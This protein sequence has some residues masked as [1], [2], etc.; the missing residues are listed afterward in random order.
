MSMPAEP[1]RARDRAE[2]QPRGLRVSVGCVTFPA[3]QSPFPDIRIGTNNA[4]W[5]AAAASPRMHNQCA[6]SGGTTAEADST[7]ICMDCTG[8]RAH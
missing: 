7:R 5:E 4:D 8:A 1:S 3:V 6:S 2:R